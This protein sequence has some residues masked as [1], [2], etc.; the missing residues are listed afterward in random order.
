MN[1]HLLSQLLDQAQAHS[2]QGRWLHASQAYLRILAECPDR[3]DI[4]LKLASVYADM[5]R[6]DIAEHTLLAAL[7]R[8]R[9]NADLLYALGMIFFDTGDL[10]RALYYF[11]KLLPHKLPQVH[12]MLGR[13]FAQKAE[14]VAAERH[15]RLALDLDTEC[16]AAAI[17]LAQLLLSGGDTDRAL[18][19]LAEAFGRDPEDAEIRF[20]TG[21]ALSLAA[22]RE[23]ALACFRTLLAEHP[24][25]QRI[26]SATA[27][28][29]IDLAKFDDAEQLLLRA[30][31]D[32]PEN[33][34]VLLLLGTVALHRADRRRAR[35]YFHRVLELDPA[36][37]EALKY[38]AISKE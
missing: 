19:F 12:L 20:L 27:R 34:D 15:Y 18:E 28:M 31:A 16:R 32:N 37:V 35:R 1:E 30:A 3:V 38:V 17:A 13:V 6:A 36:N 4:S 29:L 24:E 26:V 5:G 2:E 25:D 33:V 10:D 22:R 21:I 23:E 7:G 11:E 14:P 9:Y 8:D